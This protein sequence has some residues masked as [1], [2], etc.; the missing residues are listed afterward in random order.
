MSSASINQ[1]RPEQTARVLL[2][3]DQT[4][5]TR[6]ILHALLRITPD[7]YLEAFWNASYKC[8][9]S[10]VLQAA[11][12]DGNVRLSSLLDL[13]QVK[14]DGPHQV[15]LDH[16]LSC[17]SH[18]ALLFEY[19]RQSGGVYPAPEST[20]HLGLCT[21]S[22][23]A[24]AAT[25]CQ[26]LQQLLSVSEPVCAL[27]YRLGLHV[28]QTGARYHGDSQS[29]FL[30]DSS[31]AMVMS[32][33]KLEN[34]VETI[35]EFVQSR[36]TVE[37]ASPYVGVK[38]AQSLTVYG[39]PPVLKQLRELDSLDGAMPLPLFAPYHAPHI[40]QEGDV[41]WLLD[42]VES[43]GYDVR[44]ETRS[45]ESNE[46]IKVARGKKE[47]LASALRAILLR[48]LDLEAVV[49][50]LRRHLEPIGASRVEFIPMA[51]NSSCHAISRLLSS[52]NG[53]AKG[54]DAAQVEVCEPIIQPF[55]DADMHNS[56]HQSS[57]RSKIAIVGMSCRLPKATNVDEFWDL[58]YRGLDVH[59]AVPKT[60]WDAST[61][62]D[63][64]ASPQKNTSGTPFGCW[65]GEPGDF[66]AGF[67]GMSPRECAQTDPA[68]RLALLTAYEA[69][70]DGGIVPG[71]GRCQRDRMGVCFGVTSNDWMETN[72]AQDIDTYLIPGGNR[73]FIPGRINYCLKLSGPSLAIDT[74]C[75]SSLAAIHTACNILWRGEADAM[76]TG[77][78]NILTNP[79]FTAG[80]DRGH[81]L[82]RT[83]NCKTFDDD[84]DGY[85]R[86]E[87]VVS[88]ILK[89]LPDAIADRD[90]I[91][92][93]INNICTN[94]SA[95]AESITRPSLR[96]QR[97][98]F[99][100]VLDG[101]SPVRVSYVEL[102]G[103]GTQ[104]G[105]ATEMNSLLPVLAPS[106][107][108][109]SRLE[110]Q[111]VHLGSVK[112]NVGHGEA[113]A[114][115]TSV[116][117]LLLMM[118]NST[119]PPHVGIKNK[120]NRLFPDDLKSRGVRIASAPVDWKPAGQGDARYVLVNNFSAAGGNTTLLLEDAP[121]VD[122]P[123]P[124]D[125][126]RTT[127]AVVVS[128][129]SPTALLRNIKALMLRLHDAE[130]SLPWLSY[131]T[132]ARRLHHPYRAAFSASSIQQLRDDLSAALPHVNSTSPRRVPKAVVFAYTGQ[133]T[134]H[135]GMGKQL[136]HHISSF[137][138]DVDTY[139]RIAHR[140][141]FS[142]FI[143]LIAGSETA[144]GAA[145]TEMTQLAI[146]SLQMALTKLWIS[147]G[148][149][150]S[151]VVGH[152][153]GHYAALNAAG[154]LS[155]AD[156]IFVVGTRARLLQNKCQP[157]THQMLSLRSRQSDLHDMLARSPH[158]E[159]AC[160]NG[161]SDII[162]SGTKADI[163]SVKYQLAASLGEA[164]CKLL[165]VPY[166]FHSS[167]VDSVLGEFQSSIS[168][169]AF[170][171]PS[172]PVICPRRETV[173]RSGD[174]YGS[175]DLLHHFRKQVNMVAALGAAESQ[176]VV[177]QDTVFL[178][179]GH[180]GTVTVM[181]KAILGKSCNAFATLSPSRNSWTTTVQAVNRLYEAGFNVRWD[182]YHAD[183]ANH[184]QVVSLPHYQWDLANYWIQYKN[185][186]SLR[187]GD[188]AGHAT[189]SPISTT[190][191]RV[192]AEEFLQDSGRLVL[193]SDMA[194][195]ALNA[196]AQGHRVN[197]VPLAT[198]SVYADI[199][200]TAGEY[201]STKADFWT[202]DECQMSLVNMAVEKALVPQ[203]MQAGLC[204]WLQT[205]I[206]MQRDE[207]KLAFV[208]SSLDTDGKPS[209]IHAR[210]S[211]VYHKKPEQKWIEGQRLMAQENIA[212]LNHGLKTGKCYRFTS[213]MIYGTIASLADFDK[214][215][216]GLQTIVLDNQAMA[217]GS[218][219]DFSKLSANDN[220]KFHVHPGYLDSLLQSAGFVMNAR[221]STDLEFEC[222]I[223]HGWGSLTMLQRLDPR[224]QYQ[225]F[226]QM[227]EDKDKPGIFKGTITVIDD[228]HTVAIIK[229]I[230]LQRVPTRL[231][232][233][234]LG[235][236][237]VQG[238]KS[239]P[240]NGLD[241]V[242][243]NPS[244]VVH[245]VAKESGIPVQDLS[246]DS[247]FATIGIDSLLSLLIT[248]RLR[249]ELG[250]DV[251]SAASIFDKYRTVGQL[252]A[253]YIA[254]IKKEDREQHSA[255]TENGPNL[256]S[257]SQS[258]S[259]PVTSLLLQQASSAHETAL[260]LF[261]LPD[262]SGSA[263]SYLSLPEIS[264][265][266]ELVGLLCPYRRDPH[267]MKE[268]CLDS[269][270]RSYLSEI[271]RRQPHGPYLVGGWSSGGIFAYRIAQMLLELGESVRDIILIDSP[272]PL[273]G[274][275][276]LPQS[277]FAHC[278]RAGV[279]THLE[280]E[281]QAESRKPEWLVP[282][283]EATIDMLSS[284]RP[285]PL[286]PHLAEGTLPRISIC[287]AGRPTLDGER[288]PRFETRP[289]HGQGIRFLTEPRSDFGPCGW[290]KL[291]P[292][293][294]IKIHVFADLDHFGIMR[295]EAA[296][297]LS[298][299]LEEA[300][301]DEH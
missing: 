116:V 234:V 115:A 275:D 282:H 230:Q 281:S 16:G 17:V 90:A 48:P 31:W 264:R 204:Q 81:F 278:T 33:T 102:H 241:T 239:T 190:I 85:C 46:S 24:A 285:T 279:L 268:A 47:A 224:T 15:A 149:T 144:H 228:A 29:C 203:Q 232:H 19:C 74:A 38:W 13:V 176:R 129:K 139:S 291:V 79:D 179:I 207:P 237:K 117:K 10:L 245:I 255:V 121:H 105:D 64:S 272:S 63:T 256:T 130:L 34:V 218:L 294:N 271:R 92:G 173:I 284:Y 103:T 132:T 59:A 146:V 206:E 113:V 6:S 3:G 76:I 248:S 247:E 55:S 138:Q 108:P 293:N 118:K 8:L 99:S 154:V 68:Q 221:D 73:A 49:A 189:C 110:S 242:E 269:L 274:L 36:G 88:L 298:R 236:A 4:E 43:D 71:R 215:Y 296:R 51:T 65:L 235:S 259:R 124:E 50:D 155:E 95:E 78:T 180:T 125:D 39:P 159:I 201:L 106:H 172:I 289:E 151:S 2:Y 97:H 153:L 188:A 249:D 127:H 42:Q 1:P 101:L 122:Q 265:Q 286:Q 84:A 140:A 123:L 194:S 152:S 158:V 233:S 283:F 276:K 168:G 260:T 166:A 133:G 266:I 162:L 220:A 252:K 131:T 181:L 196:V 80:L 174:T 244:K 288:F 100:K 107:G 56:K 137:R 5:D 209:I 191:H 14:L 197:G 32:K 83:G 44:G 240:V 70:E 45:E 254:S 300:I 150:P 69:L 66:D 250:F 163:A 35:H 273:N 135:V 11:I 58:L 171:P 148:I 183:F 257:G 226:V 198:P 231:L 177:T 216:R 223:N 238:Q 160:V 86:G 12:G 52:T 26:S 167:Q 212:S 27:A 60:R 199:A 25:S 40:Y 109:Q 262:G 98:L 96:A 75:S 184:L 263:A 211:L 21:G 182:E 295:G 18:F 87:G 114:G 280:Q 246:D 93:V 104:I 112:A 57:Q 202:V 82:S 253:G 208:F 128:A 23:A 22:L 77:G 243:M 292:V 301:M 30:V 53:C 222:F 287:W 126:P 120:L 61:H 229:D 169:V 164:S 299:Y 251:G 28:A 175:S 147:W 200:L 195:S 143:H 37:E 210:C 91:K 258:T 217:A 186:W 89:R 20:L 54:Q 94:H 214:G 119:I 41:E 213:K 141:G 219:V 267:N 192:V 297:R 290:E 193:H 185:D 136:Y 156:T 9:R 142:S 7:P 161:P 227:A 72:S 157:G 170:H 67:F 187:K 165:D 134:H 111:L 178:E 277:F 270:A 225:S 205:E 145:S 62:V 261:L